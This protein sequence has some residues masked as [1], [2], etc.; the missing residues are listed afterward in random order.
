MFVASILVVVIVNT[1]I[2]SLK[3]LSV[4]NDFSDQSENQRTTYSDILKLWAILI[5]SYILSLTVESYITWIPFYSSVKFTLLFFL[6]FPEL[7]LVN[8]TFDGFVSPL[9]LYAQNRFQ[10]E[11]I[12]SMSDL[13]YYIL[14]HALAIFFPHI[15]ESQIKT[16]PGMSSILVLFL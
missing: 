6:L 10:K 11:K 15:L 12:Q 14:L 8:A 1:V 7:R 5:L 13:S 2:K 4:E 16:N 3:Q 9:Y